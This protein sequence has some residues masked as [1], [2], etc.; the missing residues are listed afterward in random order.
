MRVRREQH[1]NAGRVRKTLHGEIRVG[2]QGSIWAAG[3]RGGGMHSSKKHNPEDVTE[4]PQGL[5]GCLWAQDGAQA[6]R[7][8]VGEATL[9][10]QGRMWECYFLDQGWK[11]GT[12]LYT[13]GEG[14]GNPLQ[15]SCLENP[16]DRGAWWA[17][18]PGGHKESDTTEQLHFTLL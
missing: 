2:L 17:T 3:G 16:M 7:T 5:A 1:W 4:E 6:G 14:N 9:G 11:Q 13:V 10:F 12:N 15:C 18:S 8:G